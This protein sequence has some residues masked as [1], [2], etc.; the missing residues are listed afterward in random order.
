VTFLESDETSSEPKGGNTLYVIP[1][2][3]VVE[4]E[5][6]KAVFVV[7]DGKVQVKPVTIE[8][9]VGTDVFV[10]AG[11]VGTERIIVDEQLNRL[12]S[13]DRVDVTP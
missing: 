2:R 6:G 11:L 7:A 8:K 5:E 3:A 10:S 1:K 13:G 12:K 4:R 9:E